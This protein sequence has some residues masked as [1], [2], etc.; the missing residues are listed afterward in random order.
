[1]NTTGDD[2]PFPW[3]SVFQRTFSFSLH[4]VGGVPAAIPSPLGPRNPGHESP[5]GTASGRSATTSSGRNTRVRMMCPFK[6]E[7]RRVDHDSV[8]GG[9]I[10]YNGS[11]CAPILAEK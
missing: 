2:Q 5:A 1:M 9:Q 10:G 4:C 8:P 7:G 11:D 6:K 3:I